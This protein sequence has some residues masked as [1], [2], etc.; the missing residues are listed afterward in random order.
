L[1]RERVD[2]APEERGCNLDGSVYLVGWLVDEVEGSGEGVMIS[3][4]MIL[5]VVLEWESRMG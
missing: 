5:G 2:W 1:G 3:G 4:V